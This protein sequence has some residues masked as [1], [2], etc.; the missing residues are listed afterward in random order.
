MK[1]YLPRKIKDGQQNIIRTKKT[2]IK[3]VYIL[4][5]QIIPL[6]RSDHI[7][8]R[9][10]VNKNAS[11]SRQATH[12]KRLLA[13]CNPSLPKGYQVILHRLFLLVH[14]VK[15]EGICLQ[16]PVEIILGL[17]SLN[18]F[19]AFH[20]LRTKGKIRKLC[21]PGIFRRQSESLRSEWSP[22]NNDP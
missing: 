9:L 1:C 18:H 2:N 16:F 14:R 8:N 17:I 7:H 6:K 5:K 21:L 22:I 13:L 12:P 11:S 15:W 20:R 19:L 3:I 10:C 4:T